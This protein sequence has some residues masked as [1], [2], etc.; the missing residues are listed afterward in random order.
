MTRN[1]LT[2]AAAALAMLGSCS[3]YAAPVVIANADFEADPEGANLAI[4]GWAI[5]DEGTSA[6]GDANYVDTRVG[7]TRLLH[8][9]ANDNNFV[10]Q[11]LAGVDATTAPTYEVT[12][13]YGMRTA[14][15]PLQTDH[16]FDITA[17]ISIWDEVADVELAGE[18]LTITNPGSQVPNITT[19]TTL[20]LTYDNTSAAANAIQLRIT[21]LGPSGASINDNGGPEDRGWR[22]TAYF[23]N[24]AVDAVPEPSSFA[25]LGL[26]GF[27]MLRRRRSM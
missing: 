25:L 10:G 26:G 23:D 27:F 11:T 17:R 20:S 4:T 1:T 13:D 15:T 12:F 18:T 8:L 14:A 2:T 9:K 6:T 3:A 22:A 19:N 16:G 7:L 21:H 5:D 24:F